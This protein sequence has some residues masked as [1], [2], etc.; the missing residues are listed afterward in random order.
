MQ[1]KTVTM[2]ALAIRAVSLLGL[3]CLISWEVW[4]AGDMFSTLK[5]LLFL[6]FALPNLIHCRG[7]CWKQVAVTKEVNSQLASIN[8][9]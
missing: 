9:L 6:M 3:I 2:R 4:K 7:F 8:I 1:I 5:G